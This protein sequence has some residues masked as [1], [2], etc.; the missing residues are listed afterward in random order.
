MYLLS[1]QQTSRYR[2][3]D[4]GIGRLQLRKLTAP[5]FSD[6]SATE[7]PTL[8]SVTTSAGGIYKQFIHST[9]SHNSGWLNKIRTGHKSYEAQLRLH[10]DRSRGSKQTERTHGYNVPSALVD[11]V[12]FRNVEP[13]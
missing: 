3:A 6:K 13:F 9:G 4:K 12:S 1:E 7:P 8:G 11:T 10:E 2:Q 5:K